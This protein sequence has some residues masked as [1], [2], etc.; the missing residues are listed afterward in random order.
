[1]RRGEIALSTNAIVTV[2]IALVI[3]V[4]LIVFVTGGFTSVSDIFLGK[5]KQ[6]I[7]PQSTTAQTLTWAFD[8]PPVQGES[9]LLQVSVYNEGSAASNVRLSLV[10]PPNILL[11]TMQSS[12]KDIPSRATASYQAVGEIDISARSGQHICTL[13][14]KELSGRVIATSDLVL[15]LA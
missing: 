12:T 14:A 3:L 8:R 10:C 6:S 1:M 15:S 7:A 13:T 9:Y 2:V 5:A 11:G 4:L